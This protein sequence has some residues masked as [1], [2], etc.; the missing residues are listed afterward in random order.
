[1]SQSQLKMDQE[2]I[3]LE[4]MEVE[5]KIRLDGISR[6]EKAKL[7]CKLGK[8][9]HLMGDKEQTKVAFAQAKDLDPKIQII[10]DVS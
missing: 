3:L 2:K 9:L 7:Y 8:L 6:G 1:M 5:T 10:E 4:V